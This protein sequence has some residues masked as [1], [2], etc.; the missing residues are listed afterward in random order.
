[1]KKL[2]NVN[3]KSFLALILVSIL[4]LSVASPVALAVTNEEALKKYES[5]NPITQKV[6]DFSSMNLKEGETKQE[7]E[8]EIKKE[9]NNYTIKLNNLNA[10]K[11]I[12]PKDDNDIALQKYFKE[13]GDYTQEFYKDLFKGVH[14]DY[15][16]KTH[17]TI[18]LEGNNKINGYGLVGR[19]L[20]GVTIKGEGSLEIITHKE[21]GKSIAG[22]SLETD[23]IKADDENTGLVIDGTNITITNPYYWGIDCNGDM[24]L[25]GKSKVEVKSVEGESKSEE[26]GDIKI[27]KLY[28]ED[29][30]SIKASNK[31][32]VVKDN[33][34]T[35]ELNNNIK[36][37]VLDF[38]D[39]KTYDFKAKNSYEFSDLDENLGSYSISK[40]GDNYTIILNN[41]VAKKII[42][43]HDEA[44][45]EGLA[46]DVY[47]TVQ[48]HKE[49]RT[50]ITI[51]LKGNSKIT[52]YGIEGYYVKGLTIKGDK[53]SSLDIVTHLE[54]KKDGDETI[55]YIVP[56]ISIETD[57]IDDIDK[58]KGFVLDNAKVTIT[59]PYYWGIVCNG[60]IDLIS[61]SILKVQSYAGIEKRAEAGAISTDKL[62]VDETSSVNAT[63]K[64]LKSKAAEQAKQE[65]AR[66]KAKYKYDTKEPEIELKSAD[67][68]DLKGTTLN[69]LTDNEIQIYCEQPRVTVKDDG[70][71]Y[72]V[73]VNGETIKDF[74]KGSNDKQKSFIV[75]GYLDCEKTI[76]VT[77][78]ND[79]SKTVKFRSN[80]DHISSAIALNRKEATCTEAGYEEDEYYCLIC[81]E[82]IKTE[83]VTLPALGHSFK[84]S[85]YSSYIKKQCTRCSLVETTE[86][87]KAEAKALPKP[88]V[89]TPAPAATPKTSTPQA[90]AAK[91]TTPKT[92]TSKAS[93]AKTT[94]PQASA[95]K[96]TTSKTSTPKASVAKATT[97][98]T[99]TPKAS[100]TKAEVKKV[101]K[102][103]VANKI[104]ASNFTK[105]YSSKAQ[106][107]KI[108]AKRNGNAK[109][110]YKSNNKNITVNSSGKVTVKA[111]YVGKATITIK[112]AATGD[113]KAATKTIT[114]TVN[115][116][117]VKLSK[118]TN[119]KSKKMVIK[120][121]KN[122]QVTGYQIQ[123]STDKNFKKNVKTVTV[124]K[125][126][127]VSKTVSKLSKNKKY[128]VRVRTYKTVS[129]VKYCSS[130]SNVKNIK[131]KK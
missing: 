3:L 97:P 93:A 18:V 124:S 24:K 67:G 53:D 19:W 57:E 37:K 86:V 48:K 23:E 85:N 125:N 65:E 63:G 84:V 25:K 91:A 127:T 119:K 50:H 72:K 36:G 66:E 49:R 28:K 39:I 92:S 35:Y 16:R 71:I 30:A 76:T 45:L 1:M 106:S 47:P 60:D 96:A 128:Y 69:E 121:A 105:K 99:S 115:P 131:I 89:S 15:S 130:W 107:F 126:K 56:G 104:T 14:I 110:T 81:D 29:N 108:N 94:T 2:L 26:F 31:I 77:D 111:K 112:S 101:K 74:E 59:N 100:G 6:I 27:N 32:L 95:A 68:S 73:T 114:V 10:S 113:Y 11:V 64:I 129:K 9:G 42:L 116:S 90:S 54:Q 8:Y 4:M 7:A 62:F 88:Q 12:L 120:W 21:N 117:S 33:E 79:N 83:K 46:D 51:E 75:P 20:K 34:L 40:N 98:K 44:D 82:K 123:Y 52:G 22:I 70:K 41:L 80:S 17:V 122:T 103:Q 87:K 43:P 58:E 109:L 13:G 55:D 102:V 78:M 118:L 38:S 61:N 5:D